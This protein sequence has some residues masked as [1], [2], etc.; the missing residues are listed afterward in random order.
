M[1]YGIS[2]SGKAVLIRVDDDGYVETR[3]LAN[4]RVIHASQRLHCLFLV[5]KW[6]GTALEDAATE[7]LAAL[8]NE[9]T[10]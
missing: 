5:Q 9:A 1:S 6:R 8:N 10:R 2:P 4:L 7:L 3:D